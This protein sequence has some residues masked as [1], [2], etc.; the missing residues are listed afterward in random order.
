MKKSLLILHLWL[1]LAVTLQAD[2]A[3]PDFTYSTCREGKSLFLYERTFQRN[4]WRGDSTNS[5]WLE[6]F[7]HNYARNLILIKEL[8]IDSTY[9]IPP[10]VHQIWLGSP[11]PVKY[12]EWMS[13]WMDWHGWAYRLWTDEDLKDIKLYNQELFDRA[14]NYGEKSDILRFEILLKYGGI[15][16]DVDFECINPQFFNELHHCYD[17]YIGFEPLEHGLLDGYGMFKLCNALMGAAPGHPILQELILNLKDNYAAHEHEWPVEKTG[18]AYV[19]RTIFDYELNNPR[20]GFRNMYLPPTF[21]YAFSEPEVRRL[22]NNNDIALYAPP[23]T[24]AIH[25]WGHSWEE[26]PNRVCG[27]LTFDRDTRKLTHRNEKEK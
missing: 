12:K 20:H 19:S 8:G 17:L 26:K 4:Q 21:F 27:N 5:K 9:R 6:L 13:T 1:C 22:L 15:Y 2:I 3:Y 10:I 24:A 23:E 25:Y 18:P 7:R 16:V 11:T 14:K